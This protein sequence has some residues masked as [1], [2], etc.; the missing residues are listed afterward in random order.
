M[1]KGKAL[2]EWH[3]ENE[4]WARSLHVEGIHVRLFQKRKSGKFYREVRQPGFQKHRKCIDT[5]DR[6]EAERTGRAL[7]ARLLLAEQE[8]T[9]PDTPEA[10]TLGALLDWYFQKSATFLDNAEDSQRKARTSG[11]MLLAHFTASCEVSDLCAD[12]VAAYTRWRKA[13]RFVYDIDARTGEERRT[14]PVRANAV[15]ADLRVLYAALRWATTFRV[16]KGR[17]LL[18]RHPL[19][20]VP[21][22]REDEPKRPIATWERFQKTRTATQQLA[23][24]AEVEGLTATKDVTRAAA[25][26]NRDKWVRVELFL[27]LLEATGRRSGSIRQLRWEDIDLNRAEI[28][29]R[30]ENDKKRR[31]WIVPIPPSLVEELRG[32]QQKLGSTRG[33]VFPAQHNTREPARRDVLPRQLLAAERHAGLAK[34]DGGV[35]HPYRR[36]WA[37]ER[38]DRSMKDVAA[39]GGWR[40]FDTLATCYQQEDRDT[41]LAVMSETKKLSDAMIVGKK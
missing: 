20:G 37:T 25:K 27:V 10:L 40:D 17:R 41:M 9:P 13:G 3:E 21:R 14:R 16:S 8:A 31:K 33:Y 26:A 30:A 5:Y 22:T 35:C 36:K 11:K 23:D 34:L 12:D 4:K 7:L 39:A 38:K 15:E 32:F 19:Q 2:D 24:S 29:W 28:T 18:D 6:D 1:A